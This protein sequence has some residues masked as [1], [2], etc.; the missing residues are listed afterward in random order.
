MINLARRS[1]GGGGRSGCGEVDGGDVDDF[2]GAGAVE[3]G[4]FGV[5]I[6]KD[7][8]TVFGGIEEGLVG[9]LGFVGNGGN[10]WIFAG[11]KLDEPADFINNILVISGGRGYWCMAGCPVKVAGGADGS[12]RNEEE[13]SE[14]GKLA[15][16]VNILY[17][18]TNF[19]MEL[20]WGMAGV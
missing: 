12:Q 8:V 13:D 7:D 3:I 4:F 11:R 6:D 19:F 9:Q 18:F 10:G 15:H 2:V 14:D 16:G 5:G 20:G 1:L 17:F